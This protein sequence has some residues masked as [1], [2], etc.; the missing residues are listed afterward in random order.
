MA[1]ARIPVKADDHRT[2][3]KLAYQIEHELIVVYMPE[4]VNLFFGLNLI[5]MALS[6][7]SKK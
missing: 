2:C 4:T 3:G 1:A 6:L 7:F 5:I